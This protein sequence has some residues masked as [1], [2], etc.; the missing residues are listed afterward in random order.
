V[1]TFTAV[2]Q[3]IVLL[4]IEVPGGFAWTIVGNNAVGLS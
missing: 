3:S 4:A 2:R 1:M